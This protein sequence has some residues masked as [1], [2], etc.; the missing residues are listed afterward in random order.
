MEATDV[1][2]EVHEEVDRMTDE[3]VQ[4]LKEYMATYPDPVARRIPECTLGRRTV[5]GGRSASPCRGSG[6]ARPKRR[7]GDPL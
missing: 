6:V 4:G 5:Y 3:E 1:R 7:Q 2:K